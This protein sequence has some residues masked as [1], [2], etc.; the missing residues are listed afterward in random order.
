MGNGEVDHP[1]SGTF[2]VR[3]YMVMLPPA[4]HGY[5]YVFAD[6]NAPNEGGVF[7]SLGPACLQALLL[8]EHAIHPKRSGAMP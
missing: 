3:R 1:V 8:S 6:S 5:S 4:S 2:S 7:S